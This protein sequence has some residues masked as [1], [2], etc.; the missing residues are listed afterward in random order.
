MRRRLSWVLVFGTAALATCTAA[1]AESQA[2]SEALQIVQAGIA[3]Q[4]VPACNVCHGSQGEGVPAQN[5]PRLARL[6]AGYLERQLAA[7]AGDQRRNAVMGPIA[8]ALTPQQRATL[9]GYFA[10]LPP[11]A[12]AAPVDATHLPRGREL[13]VS[14]DWSRDVPPCAACHGPHGEGVGS[15]TP[16]LVGQTEAYLLAQLVAFQSGERAG[17]IGLMNG[18]VSRLSPS[19]LHGAAAYYASLPLPPER[20]PPGE[21]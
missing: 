11:T 14:G 2:S 8:R 3:S 4:G 12:T 15:V 13:A 16:P 1:F 10:A 6:D 5:A 17:L 9:A 18:I 20:S 7:F 21:P 19:D